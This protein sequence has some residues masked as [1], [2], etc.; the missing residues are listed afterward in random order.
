VGGAYY[1]DDIVAEAFA[2][3]DGALLPPS[4][5]GLGVKLDEEKLERFRVD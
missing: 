5:P 2:V 4:G 3:A 1:E